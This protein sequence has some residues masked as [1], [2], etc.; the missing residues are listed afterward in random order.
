MIDSQK[1][2]KE[3]HKEP[4]ILPIQHIELQADESKSPTQEKDKIFVNGIDQSPV[5]IKPQKKI[6]TI[7]KLFESIGYSKFQYVQIFIAALVNIVIGVESLIPNLIVVQ[8]QKEMNVELYIAAMLV[9][10]FGLGAGVGIHNF[11]FFCIKNI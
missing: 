8:I 2:Q 9:A 10:A 6:K 5:E 1:S 11:N 4:L 7:D 3:E